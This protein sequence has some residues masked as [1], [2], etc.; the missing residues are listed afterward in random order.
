MRNPKFTQGMDEV[1]EFL[2]DLGR[3]D[4]D[5]YRKD[6]ILWEILTA[7]RGPDSGDEVLKDNTTAKL[8]GALFHKLA[9]ANGAISLERSIPEHVEHIDPD[10]KEFHFLSHFNRAVEAFRK[11]K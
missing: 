11:L 9:R 4:V 1:F 3:L 8:R 6:H 10:G 5:D 2:N 7:L